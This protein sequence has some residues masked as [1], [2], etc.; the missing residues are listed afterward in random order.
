MRKITQESVTQFMSSEFIDWKKSN[1]SV[2]KT[3]S[4]LYSYTYL[5]L[6]GNCIAHRIVDN[7]GDEKIEI[8]NAGW[9][10]TTTKERLN[11]IR[12]VSIQQKKGIWYLNWVEWNGN[13]IAI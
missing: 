6:H 5:Y 9:F 1:M 4:S 12:G 2:E 7:L 3:H 8:S 11:G 13:W 10:S